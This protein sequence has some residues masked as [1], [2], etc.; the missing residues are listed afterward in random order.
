MIIIIIET[1]PLISRG[2]Q[3]TGLYSGI[4]RKR[5]P[6]VQKSVRFKELPSL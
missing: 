3:W 1:S 4:S 2:N 5:T 6:L